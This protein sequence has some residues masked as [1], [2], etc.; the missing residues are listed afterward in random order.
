[1]E[2]ENIFGWVAASCSV[3]YFLTLAFPFLKVLLCKLNYEDSPITKVVTIY[4]DC[5]TWFFYSKK[6]QNE[7][8]CIC[9]IIGGIICL[10]SIFIYLI[11]EVRKY[12]VD[13]I[14]NT[15]ILIVGTLIIHKCLQEI[16]E[17]S[18]T[19]AKFCVIAKIITY[20]IPTT[21]ILRAINEKN[22]LHISIINSLTWLTSCIGWA[23][24][25]KLINNIYILASNLIGIII[26]LI[27]I[28]IYFN[29]RQYYRLGK[30]TSVISTDIGDSNNNRF[31]N[32]N[33][34]I[35]GKTK[36]IKIISKMIE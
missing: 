2:S 25:G 3:S 14:L 31:K 7:P 34:Q 16:V 9:N 21:T 12:T 26:S 35:N 17:E 5:L 19:V 8:L 6:I 32:E 29:Y 4:L 24:F 30:P 20:Y 33:I 28:V 27:Q 11:F 13:T 10:S 18:K 1:M 36:R 23:V 22:F 15:L